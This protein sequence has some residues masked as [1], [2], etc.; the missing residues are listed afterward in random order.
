MG[1][2][3][4]KVHATVKVHELSPPDVY[5]LHSSPVPISDSGGLDTCCSSVDVMLCLLYMQCYP[6][7]GIPSLQSIFVFVILFFIVLQVCPMYVSWQSRQSTSY[8]TFLFFSI[9]VFC[10]TGFS[11]LLNVF[12]G[13]K[14]VFT[15]SGAHTLSSFSL[16]P[17]T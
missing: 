14:M 5:G 7:L 15:P 4:V 9:G 6:I 11:S 8:R 2:I 16:T 1:S 12:W 17:L 10:F 13:L 3:L